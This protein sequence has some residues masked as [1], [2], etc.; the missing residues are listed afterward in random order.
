MKMRDM[1]NHIYKGHVYKGISFE[2][3]D[4]WL[5]KYVK[6][7]KKYLRNGWKLYGGFER[8]ALR[9]EDKK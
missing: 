7:L 6:R 5:Y 1:K 2:I 9:L 4:I 3:L 8:A